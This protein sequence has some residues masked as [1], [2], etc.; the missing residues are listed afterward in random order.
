[1]IRFLHLAEVKQR[2]AGALPYGLQ[3]R[4][5]LARALVA[6]P[7]L[8]LLDEPLAGMTLTEK[9]DSRGTFAT[10]VTITAR[11]SS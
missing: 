3:K 4:I 8:L 7:K 9:Q 11:R 6:R 5:E 1:V 2:I 10:R